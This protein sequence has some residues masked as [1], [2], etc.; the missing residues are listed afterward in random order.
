MTGEGLDIGEGEGRLNPDRE[1]FARG[2]EALSAFMVESWRGVRIG[3]EG[4]LAGRKKDVVLSE[5]YIAK[6][7]DN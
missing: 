5:L 2:C 3:E 6:G 7:S 1:S 4:R